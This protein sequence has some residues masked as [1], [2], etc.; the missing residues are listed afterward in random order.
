MSSLNR[1]ITSN[2]SIGLLIEN[3]FKKPETFDSSYFIGKSHFEKDGAQN[4][5][6]FQPVYRYFKIIAGVGNGNYSYD[7]QSKG[8]SD[9]RINSIIASNYSV[10]PFL[11]YYGTKRRIEFSGSYLKQDKIMYTHGKVVNIYEISIVYEISKGIN[12]SAYPTLENWVFG[13]DSLTKNADIDKYGFSGYGIGLYRHEDFSFPCTGLGRNVQFFGV[14]MSSSTK[15]DNRK[16]YILI[17][18][19][20][21]TQGL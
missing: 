10:T 15:I 4:Y 11:D 12:I 6:V 3:E 9:E 21:P 1:K 5:L 16:K 20:G 13:A 17:L 14:D 8:F 2:K 18:G 7:W 19:K